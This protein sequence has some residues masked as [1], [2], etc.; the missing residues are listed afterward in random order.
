MI[1][2]NRSKQNEWLIYDGLKQNKVDK[3]CSS[4]NCVVFKYIMQR[5]IIFEN[6]AK[7]KNNNIINFK[8]ALLM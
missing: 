8:Y 1:D 6:Y 5:L 7:V 2:F 3:K 4:R